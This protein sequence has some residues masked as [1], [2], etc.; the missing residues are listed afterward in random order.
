MNPFVDLKELKKRCKDPRFCIVCMRVRKS[1]PVD[2]HHVCRTCRAGGRVALGNGTRQLPAV[3]LK[4]GR[5]F[6]K[7]VD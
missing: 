1:V 4:N 2:K 5:F 3:T 7:R 6:S